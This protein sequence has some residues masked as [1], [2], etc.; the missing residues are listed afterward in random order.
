MTLIPPENTGLV[1]NFQS[2]KT[3]T[4]KLLN[5]ELAHATGHPSA[6]KSVPAKGISGCLFCEPCKTFA[7][8]EELSLQ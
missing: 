5:R 4:V 3:K 8:I 2:R 1:E 6:E 7:W